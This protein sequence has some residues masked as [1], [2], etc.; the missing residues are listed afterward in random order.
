MKPL[1]F[2]SYLF[3]LLFFGGNHLYD[4]TSQEK[5]CLFTNNNSTNQ[6]FSKITN[7]NHNI[8]ILEEVDVDFEEEL[9]NDNSNKIKYIDKENYFLKSWQNADSKL[10]VLNYLNNRFE[11]FSPFS[12]YSN[13]IYISLQVL[14]I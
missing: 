10:F 13:P 6:K 8:I 1:V 14:R 3:F 7:N 9:H 2:F 12:G 5:K 11:I 4:N